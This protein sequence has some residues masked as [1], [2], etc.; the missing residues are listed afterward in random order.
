MLENK[1]DEWQRLEEARE[2]F[3]HELSKNIYLYGISES[4]GRL[5]G[6]VLFAESPM[7]L[8]QMSQELKMSK[9][10]MSTGIRALLEA[11]MVERVW[12]K[13]VRKDLYETEN[14][15]YKSFSTVFVKRWRTSVDNNLKAVYK[16]RSTLA[17]LS[18]TED[19]TLQKTIETDTAKLDHAQRYYEWLQE[20]IAL[21]ESEEIFKII[22]KK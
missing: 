9:T 21:F 12:Q 17:E 13:G 19:E 7:T 18:G 5:Y 1:E 16:L 22:P 4:V 11:N 20:V 2:R 14:D 3:I 8:D 6:T 15:W 10:S